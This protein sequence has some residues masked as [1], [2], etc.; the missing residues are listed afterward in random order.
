MNRELSINFKILKNTELTSDYHNSSLKFQN[1]L[2]KFFGKNTDLQNI[3]STQIHEYKIFKC[4]QT[5]LTMSMCTF[6]SA[7]KP[8]VDFLLKLF[9]IIIVSHFPLK[10]LK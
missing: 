7:C 9:Y 4:K 6:G 10:Y 8:Q 1:Y 2:I 3:S 5:V